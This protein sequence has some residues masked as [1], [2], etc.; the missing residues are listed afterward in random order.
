MLRMC[1]EAGQASDGPVL[2]L[3]PAYSLPDGAALGAGLHE[4]RDV[5]HK[6]I[7]GVHDPGQVEGHDQLWPRSIDKV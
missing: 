4:G 7:V 6:F 3:V 1:H 5:F 2:P